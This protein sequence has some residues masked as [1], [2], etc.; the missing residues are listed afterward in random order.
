MPNQD[1]SWNLP[2]EK[3]A[4]NR[5]RSQMTNQNTCR[6][7]LKEKQ[8]KQPNA[9]NPNSTLGGNNSENGSF[10]GFDVRDRSKFDA[11]LRDLRDSRLEKEKTMDGE[12]TPEASAIL[13]TLRKDYER[14]LIKEE[15]YPKRVHC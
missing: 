6:N 3:F 10:R 12:L 2:K 8:D 15:S 11:I 4:V 1:V 13:T 14:G 5:C 9:A 7:P